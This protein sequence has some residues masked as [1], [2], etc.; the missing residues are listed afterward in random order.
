MLEDLREKAEGVQNGGVE[1]VAQMGGPV[2]KRSFPGSSSLDGEAQKR[3][4]GEASV[5]DLGKLK[6]FLLF[7]VSCQTQWVKVWAAWVEPLLRVKF[8]VSLELNVSDH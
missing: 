2:V 5:L 3:H 6:D 8:G 4:H 1:R 7:R